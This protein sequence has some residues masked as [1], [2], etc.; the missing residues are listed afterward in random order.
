MP[1]TK[2]SF[3]VNNMVANNVGAPPRIIDIF[4]F[5]TAKMAN[6]FASSEASKSLVCEKFLLKKFAIILISLIGA[7]WIF[8][9]LPVYQV[10]CFYEVGAWWCCIGKAKSA[11]NRV[12]RFF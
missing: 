8:A 7:V 1:K 2:Q 11:K 9:L 12:F 5:A 10:L 4:D 6:F 3:I